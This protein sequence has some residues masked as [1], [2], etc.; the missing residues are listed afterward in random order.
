MRIGFVKWPYSGSI[1][2]S[3]WSLAQIPIMSL[4]SPP[5]TDVFKSFIDHINYVPANGSQFR[6]FLEVVVRESA[7]NN[8]IF[9]ELDFGWCDFE[10]IIIEP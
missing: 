8:V 10:N 6:T 1:I 7:N 9:K 2:K 4:N 3:A 5:N